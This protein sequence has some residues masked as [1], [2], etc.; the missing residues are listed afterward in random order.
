MNKIKKEE[1][2]KRP[3]YCVDEPSAAGASADPLMLVDGANDDDD[4][5]AADTDDEAEDVES[6]RDNTVFRTHWRRSETTPCGRS[7]TRTRRS[8]PSRSCARS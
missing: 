6:S 5:F 3:F 4:V 2:E 1:E 7:G 8:S